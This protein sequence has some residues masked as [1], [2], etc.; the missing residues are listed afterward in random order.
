MPLHGF[1]IYYKSTFIPDLTGL[2][3][4]VIK[5]DKSFAGADSVSALIIYPSSS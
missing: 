2:F 3:Q 4:L 1:I 5:N